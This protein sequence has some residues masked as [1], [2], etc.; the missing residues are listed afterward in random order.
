MQQIMTLGSAAGELLTTA[1][2]TV[3]TPLNYTID[4]VRPFDIQVFVSYRS[5]FCT[6]RTLTPP[7]RA[8]SVDFVGLIYFLILAFVAAVRLLHEPGRTMGAHDKMNSCL[9]TELGTWS[10]NWTST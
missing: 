7:F 4:N 2:T 9:T 5:S 1:P 6:L 3:L 10:L 8:T